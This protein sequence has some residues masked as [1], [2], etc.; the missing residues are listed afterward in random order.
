M[1]RDDEKQQIRQ[2]VDA[3]RDGV[4]GF[5]SRRPQMQM[6]AAVANT[7]GRCRDVEEAAGNGDHIAVVEAGTGTGKSF[8]AL[9][10]ALVMARSR[11]KRLVVSSSTVALQHQYAD[12]DVPTLQRLLPVP[13]TFAVAKGRR[14]YAC[15]VKLQLEAARAGQEGLDL[16][17]GASPGDAAPQHVRVLRELAE[18]FDSGR[19]SGERDDLPTPVADELWD[20]LATDR[21]GCAGSK[22]SE[23]G[24]CPFQAARQR[25][26]D[27]DLVIAN[28]DFVLAAL[29]MDG[30]SVL[31]AAQ[32]TIYVF[33]EAHGLPAK[34]VEHFSARHTLLG[35]V[36]WLEGATNASRDTVLALRLDAALMRDSAASAR[37]IEAALRELHQRIDATRGFDD[38]RA[39]RFRAGPL[40]AWCRAAG[41]QILTAGE[42]L[43]KTFAALRQHVLERAAG[44]GPLAAQI[45]SVLGFYVVRLDNLVDTW[46]LM[47]AEDADD[48]PPVARWIERHDDGAR[49]EDYTVCAAPVSASDKLR[50][51]L[52]NRASGAVVMSATLT[53]CG[54]FD[55]FLR[56]SGLNTFEAPAFLRV[57]SPFDYRRS[58]RLVVPAMRTEP[59]D[60]AAHTQELVERLPG[61]IDTLGTL[62]L[63][64]SA[65]Q[66]REVHARLP[67]AL[68]AVTLVQGSMPKGEM[69]ARHRAAVDRGQRS[70]LFGLGSL[71]EGV[72]LP[73]EQCTHVVIARLP[74]SV[75]DSPLEEARREWVAS[76]GG[77]PFIEITVPEAA[78][79]LKQGLGRL[80]RTV[81]DR[82]RVTI[83]DRRIVTR[84]W[85][86]LLMRGLP[87]FEVVVERAPAA[88]RAAGGGAGAATEDLKTPAAVG[89]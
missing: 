67:E 73:G 32:D 54:T 29:A 70:V 84:R 55:L 35:A 77:S 21:Q 69:L 18:A 3:L 17:A 31:P 87:D 51:L 85:G 27:A 1:V 40:P 36:E 22:C 9:V 56:Q 71:A 72:D 47:L 62:V 23:F 12:K 58:A 57:D 8:G 68:K 44:A 79:R 30:A 39:R 10:P 2:G 11:G 41:E 43:Q 48:A 60:A 6:I 19:W 15:T 5:R 64:T 76:R 89:A 45:L 49:A 65:R 88:G 75:P 46:R 26:K 52:W 42:E 28:H 74:F 25:V 24:R 14:R 61:L 66:M 78:V 20:R 83:L 16:D 13:F 7:L 37:R 86:A 53:S 38:K 59:T 50:R 33:D 82:G 81:H 4:A 34:A 63:F 80:L